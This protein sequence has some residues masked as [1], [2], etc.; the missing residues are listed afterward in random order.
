MSNAD[1]L[2]PHLAKILEALDAKKANPEKTLRAVVR[3]LDLLA[4]DIQR[5]EHKQKEQVSE[6]KA[7][8]FMKGIDDIRDILR[9]GG[10]K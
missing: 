8:T 9:K 5:I 4:E 3:A 10:K 2:R 1:T 7:D 6:K